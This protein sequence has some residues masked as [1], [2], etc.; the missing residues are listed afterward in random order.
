MPSNKLH[1]IVTGSFSR[2]IADLNA[3]GRLQS[4]N[5]CRMHGVYTDGTRVQLMSVH[6]AETRV[7][8]LRFTSWG[9]EHT[10]GLTREIPLHRVRRVRETF[11]A[12]RA[13]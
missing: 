8:G 4:F 6:N 5:R 13:K 1:V 7:K 3:E 10:E 12:A 9:L 2:S 11:N